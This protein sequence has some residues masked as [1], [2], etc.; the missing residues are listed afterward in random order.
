[1]PRTR[2]HFR[3]SRFNGRSAP[4]DNSGQPHIHF[5]LVTLLAGRYRGGARSVVPRVWGAVPS[6]CR[7]RRSGRSRSTDCWGAGEVFLLSQSV[8]GWVGDPYGAETRSAE[9]FRHFRELHGVSR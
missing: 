5:E 8:L 2:G 3:V 9:R 7:W 1:P 6:D 4:V